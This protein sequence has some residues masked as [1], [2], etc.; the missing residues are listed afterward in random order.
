MSSFGLAR[1][2]SWTSLLNS[3][4]LV[5]NVRVCG[6]PVVLPVAA[7]FSKTI[8]AVPATAVV[9]AELYLVMS[10]PAVQVST[11]SAAAARSGRALDGAACNPSNTS[12]AASRAVK[13]L[14]CRVIALPSPAGRGP[15]SVRRPSK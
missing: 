11:C 5:A 12:T 8:V 13:S 9:G 14:R 2:L 7:L 10:S 15:A 6:M 3:G 1:M 4:S